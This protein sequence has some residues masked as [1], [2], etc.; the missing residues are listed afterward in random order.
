MARPMAAQARTRRPVAAQ[1]PGW[2]RAGSRS[3][4]RLSRNLCLSRRVAGSMK[5]RPGRPVE[6]LGD[7]RLR[8][9]RSQTCTVLQHS[10]TIPLPASRTRAKSRARSS[11]GAMPA[12]RVVVWLLVAT[13]VLQA[14]RAAHGQ[15]SLSGDAIQ[16]TRANGPITI[17]G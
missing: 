5:G 9:K 2:R 12:P 17:D 6:E 10:D 4:E 14:P 11:K 7:G 1:Q 3:R 16:I 15:T 8:Q 13:A